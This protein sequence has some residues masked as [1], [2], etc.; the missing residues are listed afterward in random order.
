MS[1]E[2]GKSILNNIDTDKYEIYPIYIDC[3]GTWYEYNKRKIE[4]IVEYINK[5][6]VIFPVL[7]GINGEDGSIQGLFEI[8]KI[9]Y[10]GCRILASGIGMDK[11]YSK[12]LFD[13]ARN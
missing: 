12:V 4:N 8:F 7:H 9:P 3:D 5:L 1:V 10:V 13:R 6:D 11:V 2:S